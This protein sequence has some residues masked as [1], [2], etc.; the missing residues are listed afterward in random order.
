M[1]LF[2]K[3]KQ[4]KK[5]FTLV[6][7]IV[8]LVILA[9]LAAIAIPTFNGYIKK[10]REKTVAAEARTVLLA[11]NSLIAEANETGT[12][13]KFEGTATETPT[14]TQVSVQAIA[15]LAGV[16]ATAIDFTITDGELAILEYT[17]GS[18]TYEY[19]PADSNMQKKQD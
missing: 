8:V 19:I 9:I 10:A 17:K 12:A 15:N 14:A 4:N 6:E 16:S 1:G 7:L 5:G 13:T 3:M 11:A 2:K 18:I